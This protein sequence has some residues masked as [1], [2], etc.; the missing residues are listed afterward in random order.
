[1]PTLLA[2]AVLLLATLPAALAQRTPRTINVRGE[3][4]A[5]APPDLATISTGVTTMA[6]TAKEALAEN[7]RKFAMVLQV[8]KDAGIAEK[9]IQTGF[10]RVNPQFNNLPGNT[11]EL[12]GYRVVNEVNVKVRDLDILGDVLDALVTAGSNNISGVSFSLDDSEAASNEARTAAIKDARRRAQLYARAAGVRVGR[13][14]AISETAIES[15]QPSRLKSA[16][17]SADSVPI[18]TGELTINARVFVLFEMK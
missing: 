4:S 16:A 13:V 1:M 6:K 2:L 3:G 18:A 8:L 11:N 12:V 14:L 17:F 15:P 7:N 9:D 5:S 10:F